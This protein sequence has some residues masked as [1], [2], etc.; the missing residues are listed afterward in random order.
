MKH[1]LNAF[2]LFVCNSLCDRSNISIDSFNESALARRTP[3]SSFKD[4]LLIYNFA[5]DLFFFNE[6][7]NVPILSKFISLKSLKD[8]SSAFN[9]LFRKSMVAKDNAWN[10][11][12]KGTKY[13]DLS[14]CMN[15]LRT[16]FPKLL[17]KSKVGYLDG[18]G[19]NCKIVDNGGT[20]YQNLD[21]FKSP[22]GTNSFEFDDDCCA[23]SSGG[24]GDINTC[25]SSP[26]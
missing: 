16:H 11:L 18:S 9:S 14:E 13:S 25:F 21:A 15:D 7:A 12:H 2:K 3:P 26:Q 17:E 22:P 4:R 5:K 6:D 20:A 24:G 23:F 1:F 8:K 19:Y 10:V